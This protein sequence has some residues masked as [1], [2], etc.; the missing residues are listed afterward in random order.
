MEEAPPTTLAKTPEGCQ[1]RGEPNP[2]NQKWRHP[3][4]DALHPKAAT[5]SCELHPKA[6]ALHPKAVKAKFDLRPKHAAP[7][8]PKAALPTPSPPGLRPQLMRPR[9]AVA[10]AAAPE[11]CGCDFGCNAKKTLQCYCDNSRQCGAWNTTAA[12]TNRR[13]RSYTATNT[14]TT[15]YVRT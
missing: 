10:T 8:R 3:K 4:A 2:T 1:R 15:T 7:L 9:A 5:A 6:D 14:D 13:T 11:G 12:H